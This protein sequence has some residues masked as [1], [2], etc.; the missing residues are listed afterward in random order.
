TGHVGGDRSRCG[1]GAGMKSNRR[2]VQCL[3]V[4]AFGLGLASA[5]VG[6]QTAP[7]DPAEPL[8]DRPSPRVSARPAGGI[9]RGAVDEKGI[10]TLIAKLGACGTRLT[11]ASWDDPKRGPGCGRDV[12]AARLTE[13]A[14]DSG[15]KLQVVVDKFEMTSARTG[16]KPAPMENVYAIL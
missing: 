10:R 15:G 9:A 11:I 6:Q 8:K 16:D 1:R 2:F 13:I 4:L 3:T 14:K 5:A 12:V 7:R